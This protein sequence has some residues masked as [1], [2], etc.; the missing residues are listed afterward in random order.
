MNRD[1]FLSVSEK[2]SLLLKQLES[3]Q[4]EKEEILTLVQSLNSTNSL[5][6]HQKEIQARMNKNV[7]EFSRILGEIE[8]LK[9]FK[10]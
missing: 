4:K 2:L 3:C 1:E 5:V 6:S 8:A 7:E 10:N 9:N